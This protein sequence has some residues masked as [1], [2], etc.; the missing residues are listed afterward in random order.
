MRP[1]PKTP[2]EVA[3]HEGAAEYAFK[4][5]KMDGDFEEAAKEYERAL[6]IAPWLAT[7]YFNCGIAYE[8]ARKY[9]AAI[10]NLNFY[11]IAAPDAQDAY[12][13][14]KRIGGLKYAAKKAENE[15][16][17]ATVSRL[18]VSTAKET[19]RDGRFIAYSDDTVL[20]TRTKLM[21]AAKDNGYG[22]NWYDAKKY[23]ENYRGGGYT[24]WRMP[25]KDELA[26]LYDARKSRQTVCN[27]PARIATELIDITCCCPWASET[28]GTNGA[29]SFLFNNDVPD[30]DWYV[31]TRSDVFRA[32][33]VRSGK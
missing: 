26:G 19:L 33:P 20:D 2:E 7:N 4:N 22:I 13:V 29:A 32:L 6:L 21:W 5:A 12:D 27:R 23:C 15:A 28:Q 8:K 11:L 31:N 14:R 16:K 25:K 17:D 9:D 30:W 10:R 1:V 3:I 18:P 24:D